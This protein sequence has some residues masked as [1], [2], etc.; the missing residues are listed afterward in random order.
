MNPIAHALL[1]FDP[2]YNTIIKSKRLSEGLSAVV[3]V[4]NTLWVANDETTSVERL[5]LQAGG[6]NGAY[7]YG[8]HHQ[9]ALADYIRLP[10]NDETE[11]VDIEALDHA[12]GYLWFAGSHSQARKKTKEGVSAHENID[13]LATFKK[14]SN[15]FILARIPL[16][17]GPP[18]TLIPQNGFDRTAAQLHGN[19]KG[20]RLTEALEKD[21]HLGPSLHIPSKENGLDI[22]GLAIAGEH[23]F[24]G[25]RGPVLRGWAVIVELELENSNDSTLTLKTIGH[26]DHHYR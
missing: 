1:E 3:Q 24:L 21:E 2:A 7:T 19:D 6:L 8:E 17:K 26:H 10:V 13:R 9:F 23:V 22:E 18:Y 14:E 5:I 20:N 25:L 11:E 4:D 12:N 16:V 15:R